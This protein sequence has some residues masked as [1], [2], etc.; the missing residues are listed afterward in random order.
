MKLLTRIQCAAAMAATALAYAP[1]SLGMEYEVGK[2][3]H[4]VD[5]DGTVIQL[6]LPDKNEIRRM[7]DYSVT[8][9]SLKLGTEE[10]LE[11]LVRACQGLTRTQ[12]DRSIVLYRAARGQ[13]LRAAM[14]A[15]ALDYDLVS[16]RMDCVKIE[17]R[18]STDGTVTERVI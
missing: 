13:K 14:D 1:V 16:L 4:L 11:S 3:E 10:D 5:K 9:G 17:Y 6:P 2:V 15:N 8:P 12:V 7:I 18:I